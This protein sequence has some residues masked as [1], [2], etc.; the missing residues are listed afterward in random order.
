[1]IKRIRFKDF[2]GKWYYATIYVYNGYKN[3]KYDTKRKSRTTI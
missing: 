1:M 3:P 2:D